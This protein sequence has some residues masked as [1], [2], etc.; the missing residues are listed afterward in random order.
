MET[1]IEFIAALN[2]LRLNLAQAIGQRS[3]ADE[4]IHVIREEIARVQGKLEIVTRPT[5][6]KKKSE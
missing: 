6:A 4:E 5:G 3:L 2:Q 1:Q